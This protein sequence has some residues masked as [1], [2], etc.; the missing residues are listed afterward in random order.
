MLNSTLLE[1]VRQKGRGYE[2]RCPACAAAGGDNAGNHLWVKEDGRYGCVVNPGPQG[3]AHRQ[4]IYK[5]AGD[6][7]E[8]RQRPPIVWTLKVRR[9]DA[10]WK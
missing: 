7:T 6:K 4:E 1:N 9:K 8:A 3:K 5:L 2:A 10:G